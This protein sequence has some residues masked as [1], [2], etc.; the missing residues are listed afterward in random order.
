M[1]PL[2]VRGRLYPDGTAGPLEW[3]GSGKTYFSE[4]GD[5]GELATGLALFIRICSQQRFQRL[6]FIV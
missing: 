2:A 3:L 1:E 4:R 5:I 6:S